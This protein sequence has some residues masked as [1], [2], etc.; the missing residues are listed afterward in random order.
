LLVILVND[1]GFEDEDPP[2]TN[3]VEMFHPADATIVIDALPPELTVTDGEIVPDPDTI[4][5]VTV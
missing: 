5:V 3:I 4:E 1:T 2:S